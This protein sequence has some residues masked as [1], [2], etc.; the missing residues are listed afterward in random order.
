MEKGDKKNNFQKDPSNKTDANPIPQ[1]K[2][3]YT[4]RNWND[5]LGKYEDLKGEIN[6]KKKKLHK[7]K[8]NI[9]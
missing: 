2:A 6:I 3:K 1:K 5:Y 8:L 7:T 9:F 4:K